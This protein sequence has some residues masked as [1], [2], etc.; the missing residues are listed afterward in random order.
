LSY[1]GSY[2]K[3]IIIQFNYVSFA[4]RIALDYRLDDQWFESQQQLEIFLFTTASRPALRSTQP[5][6][7]SFGGDKEAGVES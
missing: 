7:V 5:T 1:S 2:C 4:S 3:L 6:R